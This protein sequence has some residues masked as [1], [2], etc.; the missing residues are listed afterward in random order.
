MITFS[1]AMLTAPF[2]RHVVT[3]MGSISGV[4]PTATDTANRAASIQSPLVKPL[5]NSTTGTITSMNRMSTHETEL[6][7][8]SK[9]VWG[10]SFERVAAVAPSKVSLPTSTTM[11]VAL[12]DTIVEPM[13]ATSRFSALFSTGSLSPVSAASLKKRSLVCTSLISAGIKS[14]ADRRTRSPATRS[15]MGITCSPSSARMT[16]AVLLIMAA[17]RA[18][19]L[20]LLPSCTKRSVP[21]MATIVEMMTTVV[22]SASPGAAKTM[23]VQVDTMASA[24]RMQV[25]GLMNAL[26]MRRSRSSFLPCSTTL[27]PYESRDCSTWARS[28]PP[29]V[30]PNRS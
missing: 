21:E 28:R 26:T 18:A 8:S 1:F 29:A 9:E 30:V 25:N 27:R 10:G 22:G 20:P 13:K 5:M 7:P 23:S 11:P 17:R 6:T 19:A 2:A 15:S 4:R 16:Q 14:P 24:M 12:P 3:I